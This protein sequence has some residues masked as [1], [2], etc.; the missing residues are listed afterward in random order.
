MADISHLSQDGS[1]ICPGSIISGCAHKEA[2][3]SSVQECKAKVGPAMLTGHLLS[4]GDSAG[5]YESSS[6][7]MAMRCTAST[8]SEPACRTYSLLSECCLAQWYKTLEEIVSK[9]RVKM[10]ECQ[11]RVKLLKQG[12][13][14]QSMCVV[15]ASFSIAQHAVNAAKSCFMREWRAHEAH[16]P[17]P[18]GQSVIH[19]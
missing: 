5:V 17:D 3:S 16:R 14:L 15:C 13:L 8:P 4:H 12:H 18:W 19:C 10:L 7:Q 9:D 11:L 1:Q 6:S 2:P